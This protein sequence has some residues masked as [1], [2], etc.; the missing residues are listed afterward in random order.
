M[1]MVQ[2]IFEKLATTR[3]KN[4]TSTFTFWDKKCL[5]YGQDW[6]K[7]FLCGLQNS[8]VIILLISNEVCFFPT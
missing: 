4:R 3:Q 1:G 5:N 6:E 2:M 7:G 8:Q